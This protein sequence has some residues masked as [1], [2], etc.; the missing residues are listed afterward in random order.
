MCKLK[1]AYG[2]LHSHGDG[3]AHCN[4]GE[5][6]NLRGPRSGLPA[7][8]DQC[9]QY[10]PLL[11]S[12]NMASITNNKVNTQICEQAVN[13]YPFPS[14]S[15]FSLAPGCGDTYCQDDKVDSV[16]ETQALGHPEWVWGIH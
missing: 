11:A 1:H 7:G 3:T 4:S 2:D 14:P 13:V 9:A 8:S 12:G 16:I 10:A 6:S 15:P 5:A